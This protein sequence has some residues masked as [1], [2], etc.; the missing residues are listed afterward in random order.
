LKGGGCSCG[1]LRWRLKTVGGVG[2]TVVEAIL[3]EEG[4]EVSISS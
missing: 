2:E 3:D 4:G 1:G